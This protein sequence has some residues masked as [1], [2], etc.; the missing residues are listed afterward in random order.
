[1]GKPLIEVK[2]AIKIYKMGDENFYALN[3]VSF[4]IDEGEFVAIMGASG[5]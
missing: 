3:D 2:N 4:K 5:S 1:M